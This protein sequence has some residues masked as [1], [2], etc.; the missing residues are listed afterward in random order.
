M[1]SDENFLWSGESVFCKCGHHIE[2]HKTGMGTLFYNKFYA[3][4]YYKG[5]KEPIDCKC[6]EFIPYKGDL[7]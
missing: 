1:S 3:H 7:S 2:Y 6:E 4:C 5:D